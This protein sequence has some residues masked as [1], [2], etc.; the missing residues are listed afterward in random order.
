MLR[1]IA[2]ECPKCRQATELTVATPD[3]KEVTFSTTGCR[4]CGARFVT[5]TQ[6]DGRILIVDG[7]VP[8]DAPADYRPPLL[9]VVDGGPTRSGY[10]IT[11]PENLGIYDR[12]VPPEPETDPGVSDEEL[13]ANVVRTNQFLRRPD[14]SRRTPAEAARF[15]GWRSVWVAQLNEALRSRLAAPPPLSHPPSIFISYRWGTDAEN[16]WTARLARE[17]KSRGY[18]VMFDRDE[19]KDLD[20]PQIVSKVADCRYFVALLDPGYAERIGGTGPDPDKTRD[21]WV[22]DEY[23]TAAML[24]NA[25]QLR[26]LGLWRGGAALPR[27]FTEPRPGV[28]GNVLDVRTPQ[29]LAAVLDDA[30]PPITDA[31]DERTVERAR[32]LLRQSHEHVCAGELQEAYERAAELAAL[33]PGVIDGPAQKLRVALRAGAHEA[34]LAAAEEALELAPDAIELLFAAGT[35]AVGLG[36][37]Q[38]AIRYLALA[39]ESGGPEGFQVAQAHYA[40]GSSL[41]EL[42]QVH[43]GLA[44]L[45]VARRMLAPNTV[46]LNTLGFVYRRAGEPER[47]VERFQE[48][49]RLDPSHVD[50]LANLVNALAESGR[51]AEG[52]AAL[53]DLAGRSPDHPALALDGPLAHAEQTGEDPPQLVPRVAP[54]DGCRWIVCDACEAR[55]PIDPKTHAVCARCGS[56]LPLTVR[57]CPHC[58]SE[59]RVFP[60]APTRFQCPYCRQGRVSLAPP[61]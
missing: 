47:A 27:G 59:G 32:A 22:F 24:S 5:A 8:S 6:R 13:R 19:P 20:V 17:L 61:A 49:L 9:A 48:G 12:G 26:I 33:L 23:N 40:L 16:E 35:S 14:G 55:V 25:G 56:V 2:I 51:Y 29:Q 36:R 34:A 3:E 54:P 4:K 1:P 45:E 42:D 57:S 15:V 52:R 38:D 43:P 37:H 30:F 39:L 7:D 31:P 41:D 10:R 11:P 53:R 46:V 21:G 58:T 28:P 18:P 60:D 50:L 44:H